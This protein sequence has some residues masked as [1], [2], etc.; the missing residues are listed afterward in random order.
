MQ[1]NPNPNPELIDEENPEWTEAMFNEA[2]TAAQLFP[3]LLKSSGDVK[4]T[5]VNKI[6][7]TVFFDADILSAFQ[8]T[9][10]MWQLRMNEALREWLHEHA[11]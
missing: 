5:R 10:E 2:K 4:T 9:G 8:A 1:H 7:E 11:L 6:S 3:Q